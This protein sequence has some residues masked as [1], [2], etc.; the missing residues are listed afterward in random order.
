MRNQKRRSYGQANR[1]RR[2]KAVEATRQLDHDVSSRIAGSITELFNREDSGPVM[3]ELEKIPGKHRVYILNPRAVRAKFGQ[4]FEKGYDFRTAMEEIKLQSG[5]ADDMLA[6]IGG[7]SIEGVNQKRIITATIVDPRLTA[8]RHAAR[9]VMGEAGMRGFQGKYAREDEASTIV[10][11]QAKI[12]IPSTEQ[13]TELIE[14]GNTD[15]DQIPASQDQVLT[16][17]EKTFAENGIFGVLSLQAIAVR[18]IKSMGN[19]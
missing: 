8:E 15:P 10:I 14:R 7:I 2:V 3:P 18:A 12:H 17:I 16:A 5:G 9:T 4:G 19:N 1:E 6:R 13:V 11:A